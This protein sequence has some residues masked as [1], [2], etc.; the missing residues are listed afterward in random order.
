[1][2]KLVCTLVMVLSLALMLGCSGD[3]QKAQDETPK[4]ID[5]AG[6]G[7]NVSFPANKAVV[8]AG[9]EF[10]VIF[11]FDADAVNEAGAWIESKFDGKRGGMLAGT[12]LESP[13]NFEIPG[14]VMTSGKHDVQFFLMVNGTDGPEV[15]A[16]ASVAFEAK[17]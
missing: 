5:I 14:K 16:S 6:M 10:T 2:K 7:A 17:D 9:R 1:M 15:R 12:T 4:I 8:P 3:G 13:H 11:E